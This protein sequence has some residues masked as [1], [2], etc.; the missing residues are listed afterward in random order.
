MNHRPVPGTT[1]FAFQLQANTIRCIHRAQKKNSRAVGYL[2]QKVIIFIV[3][4]SCVFISSE[5]D[6]PGVPVV[7]NYKTVCCK[8]QTELDISYT[9]LQTACVHD[10]AK[11]YIKL[12]WLKSDDGSQFTLNIWNGGTL[13]SMSSQSFSLLYAFVD[14]ILRYNVVIVF[15]LRLR[16]IPSN[17]RSG[18]FWIFFGSQAGTPKLCDESSYWITVVI[19][20]HKT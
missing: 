2:I 13:I 8:S 20:E 1:S 12:G 16:T 17:L 3:N 10:I 6:H 7:K 4:N 15:H 5:T 19:T 9:W 18:R 14:T 11:R